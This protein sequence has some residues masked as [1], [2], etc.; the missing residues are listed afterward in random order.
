MVPTIMS[1][2]VTLSLDTLLSVMRPANLL[3]DV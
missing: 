2:S 1:V 3:N